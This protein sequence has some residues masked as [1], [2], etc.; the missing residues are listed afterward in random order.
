[1][2]T[3]AIIT[4]AYDAEAPYIESFI[5]YYSSIGV[6]E[7]HIV[8]PDGNPA[9][10]LKERVQRYSTVKLHE[11]YDKSKYPTVQ[12]CQNAAVKDV[13]GTHILS[14]DVDEY[15]AVDGVSEL[16]EYDYVNFKWVVAPY[17]EFFSDKLRGFKDGQC[18]YLVRKDIL[19]ALRE[20]D[21]TIT[22][23]VKIINSDILLYHY[24]YRSF[25][26]LLFKCSM[27]NYNSYQRSFKNQ[28]TEGCENILKLPLKFKMNAIYRKLA[29]S[30]RFE[31]QNLIVINREVEKEM[32][33][34][35]KTGLD[36][37]ALHRALC[38]Y[39]SRINGSKLLTR[40]KRNKAFL[41]LGRLPHSR[42]ADLA[43]KSL[44]REWLPTYFFS[45]K[46]GKWFIF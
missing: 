12:G 32:A 40:V 9:T 16:L 42:L 22:K 27:S 37:E 11:N 28:F 15:L 7:F 10:I 39:E 6:E 26:D 34:S 41:T 44:E 20:H 29:S 45:K 33:E 14:V 18:K 24:V 19:L 30:Q 25:F 21:C 3:V 8:V 5:D 1:M 23:R 13:N 2:G 43:D 31:V 17:C 38:E 36:F 4:R 35:I 46:I